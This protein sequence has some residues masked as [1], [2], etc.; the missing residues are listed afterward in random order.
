MKAKQ[1]SLAA[2]SPLGRMTSRQGAN[3]LLKKKENALKIEKLLAVSRTKGEQALEI[4]IRGFNHDQA[5]SALRYLLDAYPRAHADAFRLVLD[6]SS[7][8]ERK[9]LF[10]PFVRH[11][12]EAK[13]RGRIV[14][15]DTFARPNEW[16][17]YIK[18]T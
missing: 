14:G 12:L 2:I 6:L 11:L 13:R 17:F 4:D 9:T 15:W 16:G 8:I 1:R 7:P 18:L 3:S 5:I 10:I